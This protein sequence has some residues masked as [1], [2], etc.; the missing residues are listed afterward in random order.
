[1]VTTS[2]ETTTAPPVVVGYDGSDACLAALQ[3]TLAHTPPGDP[4]VVVGARASDALDALWDA[5]GD[6]LGDDVEL[7]VDEREPVD[8]LTA[9]ARERGASLIVVGHERRHGA[10]SLLHAS[11][12]HGLL[13]HAGVPVVVVG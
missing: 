11:V 10:T 13:E 7:V 5:D 12:A 6:V 3:W 1:M 9:T 8:A 2:P 4:V